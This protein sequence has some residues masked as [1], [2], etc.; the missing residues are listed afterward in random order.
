MTARAWFD[1]VDFFCSRGHPVKIFR[2]SSNILKRKR[3]IIWRLPFWEK[4]SKPFEHSLK[5]IEAFWDVSKR[6]NELQ[7]VPRKASKPFEAFSQKGSLQMMSLFRFR[8]MARIGT[9]LRQHA[10]RT[11]PNVSLLDVEQIFRRKCRVKNVFFRKFGMVFREP[12]PNRPQ[13][14]MPRQLL[15]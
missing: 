14:Q 15:F 11:I 8:N 7:W 3:L 2:N 9:K 4:A 1:A 5:L 12:R 10:F 6:F 13:N